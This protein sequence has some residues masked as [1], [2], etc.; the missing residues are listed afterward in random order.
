MVGDLNAGSGVALQHS[1]QHRA[2]GTGKGV[3]N[4]ATRLGDLH[5]V[6]HE[7]QR[8]LCQVDAVLGIA[9]FEH[10]GQTGNG[11]VDGHIAV[12][13]PDNVFRLLAETSFLGTAVAFVPDSSAAPD[14]A[15]PLQGI[16]GS[17][18]LPPVDEYAH[19][20]AG[21]ADPS[22]FIQP[23]RRPAGPGALVLGVAVKGR[24]GAV[25]HTGIL[26][27]GGF[28]LFRLGAPAGRIGRIGDD[29]VK[30]VGG[31]ALQHLQR[32]TMDDLPLG[33]IVHRQGSPFFFVIGNG[34]TLTVPSLMIC[35]GEVFS[36]SLSDPS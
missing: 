19:R 14:P 13:T 16:R 26:P 2:A 28:V 4:T 7:L 29:R 27:G 5:D 6:T 31:K 32:V 36:R 11:P 9:V 20:G 21:L 22:G 17:G 1:S 10:T 12:G 15:S 33:M 25:S 30:G 34:N 3:Q 23:L 18:E 8:L 24:R 35:G